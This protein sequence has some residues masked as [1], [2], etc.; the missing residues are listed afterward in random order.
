LLR[1]NIIFVGNITMKRTLITI[2][3]VFS[4]LT[5]TFAQCTS[6]DLV[7][8]QYIE[9]TSN[10]KCIEFYNGTSNPINLAAG[11]Y[12]I[13]QYFNGA[14]TFSTINLTGTVP[15]GGVYV[16]CHANSALNYGSNSPNQTTA[17]SLFTGNDAIALV[18]NGTVLD[19]FGQ[20][21][22]DPGTQWGS[23]NC[24]TADNSLIRSGISSTG[25][26]PVDA[27]GADVF[28]PAT[29]AGIT[30][31]CLP[32]NDVT[33]LFLPTPPPCS[34]TDIIAPKIGYACSGNNSISFN[35][36]K[37]NTSAKFDLTVSPTVA[38]VDGRYSYSSLPLTFN[39][40]DPNA[41]YTYTV[42]DTANAACTFSETISYSNTPFSTKYTP[43]PPT[44]EYENVPFDVT[45]CVVD[46]ILEPNQCFN[47]T[48]ALTEISGVTPQPV[49]SPSTP[50]TAVNGCY[51]FS[52][53]PDIDGAMTQLRLR[54]NSVSG[55]YSGQTPVL[56][57]NIET[58]LPVELKYFNTKK[59][60]GNIVL[61]WATA[62]EENN[63]SFII[64]KSINNATF[65]YL[66][67]V[68]GKGNSNTENIYSFVD[69]EKSLGNVC[70]KLYQQ[71][72]DGKV[73]LSGTSCIKSIQ[74]IY[75]QINQNPVFNNAE[76]SVF[77]NSETIAD[78]VIFNTR[79]QKVFNKNLQLNADENIVSI[80]CSDWT[81]GVYFVQILCEDGTVLSNKLVK[82]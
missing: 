59:S 82:Q 23:G 58:P 20:I 12:A 16:L 52:V 79:G 4:F 56:T 50:Q 34:I 29:W 44:T 35:L 37:T 7:I 32:V 36:V 47:G 73:T 11:P 71:D 64:E 6:T 41:D 8:S 45:I 72:F 3:F 18:K 51:T 26:C 40:F 67:T 24:S 75:L 55:T 78:I 43:I 31:N 1:Y 49:I 48:L 60:N 5:K 10:N 15:A 76:I 69:A 65:K 22:F 19:V 77:S 68:V 39:D 63:Q 80:A 27:N 70:Y 61:Q 2:L 42:T 66:T 54:A 46:N 33:D 38:G 14:T 62:R 28:D 74:D 30:S 53:T 57:I 9:G 25:T 81:N 21:G 13:R 17:S